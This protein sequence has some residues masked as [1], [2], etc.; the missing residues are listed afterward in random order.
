MIHELKTVDP[1]WSDVASGAKTFEVRKND[2]GFSVGDTLL[3]RR[4]SPGSG[5]YVRGG[6]LDI[7]P[8]AADTV[9][10][11]VTYVLPG[12]SLGI[13]PDTCVLGLKVRKPRK[14]KADVE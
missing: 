13:A 9:W 6:D 12:G 1:Y 4:Y 11:T 5:C 8:A 7:N 14:R 3:L 10:A 2:R